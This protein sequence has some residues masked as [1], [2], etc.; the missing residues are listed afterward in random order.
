[1]VLKEIKENELIFIK[2]IDDFDV[3]ICVPCLNRYA[4]KFDKFINIDIDF[5][6]VYKKIQNKMYN[7]G[8]DV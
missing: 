6:E 4:R 1:M 7:L 2:N 3:E 5:L 8:S